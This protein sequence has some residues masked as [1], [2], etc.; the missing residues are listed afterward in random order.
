LGRILLLKLGGERRRSP[1]SPGNDRFE[2]GN[3][4]VCDKNRITMWM[5]DLHHFHER[6][7]ISSD[8]I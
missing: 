2:I 7:I 3:L 5:T 8:L 4:S 6:A 1:D